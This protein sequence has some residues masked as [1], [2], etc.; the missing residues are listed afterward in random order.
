MREAHERVRLIDLMRHGEPLGGRRYRGQIDDPLS[1]RGWEQMRRAV[2]GEPPWDRILSSPLS[3]CRAFAEDLAQRLGLPLAVDERLRE[4]G[5]GV[6]EGHTA[7]ELRARDPGILSR[8]YDD[9]V[10]NRP[11]GAEPLEDF[12]ARV[13]EAFDELLAEGPFR[14][15]LVITHAGVIRT[16]VALVLD[17]P[18]RAIYRVSVETAS[19]TRVR[20]DGERPPTLVF[21]GRRSL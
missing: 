5:F 15:T 3:R 14:H 1:D 19:L 10:H 8:F 12:L 13:S 9:P 17:A 21:Q 6:W 4:V 2:D 20:C 16:V 18:P 7:E 11:E